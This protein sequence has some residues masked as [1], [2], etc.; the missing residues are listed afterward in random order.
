MPQLQTLVLMDRTSTDHTFAPVD[1]IDRVGRVAESTGI[2]LG[3]SAYTLALRRTPTG[4]YK[5]T[6]KL[7][8]PVIQT[9]TVNGIAS[10]KV[11]R[12]AYAEA[13][14]TFDQTS[15]T[16]ERNNL[17]GMFADSLS[18]DKALTN[19]VLVSLEGVY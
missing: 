10:P 5:A 4:K 17:V 12:T 18:A 11:V 2:P 9:E 8:V 7:Q 19:G 15:T 3:N 16:A 14:F 6:L 13:T 1:I